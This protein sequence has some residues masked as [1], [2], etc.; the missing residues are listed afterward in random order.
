MAQWPNLPLWLF[1]GSS[2]AAHLLGPDGAGGATLRL[3]AAACLAVWAGDEVLRGVNPWRRLLG[4]GVLAGGA[5]VLFRT[6]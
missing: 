5:F 2:A 4:A 6:V 3:V 1:A